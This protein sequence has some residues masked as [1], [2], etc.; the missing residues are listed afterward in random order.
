MKLTHDYFRIA[1]ENPLMEEGRF[2]LA[3]LGPK[4][5]LPDSPTQTLPNGT[6]VYA[7]ED[8]IVKKEPRIMIMFPE[9][10]WMLKVDA[11]VDPDGSRVYQTLSHYLGSYKIRNWTAKSLHRIIQQGDLVMLGVLPWEEFEEWN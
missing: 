10:I 5:T 2:N 3:G 8:I 7:T 11:E 6:V 1:A 4:P 9:G